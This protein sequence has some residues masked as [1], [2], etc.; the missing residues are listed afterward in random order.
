MHLRRKCCAMIEVK[1]Q[2]KPLF[3]SCELISRYCAL[4]PSTLPASIT[5]S[6]HLY[7]Q[8]D[9]EAGSTMTVTDLLMN[10]GKLRN[11]LRKIH[12]TQSLNYQG[13]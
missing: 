11:A 5:H 8:R 12:T 9:E 6:S 4:G 7:L 3:A 2:I 10:P 1:I 13:L